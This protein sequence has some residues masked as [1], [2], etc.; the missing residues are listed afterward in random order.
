MSKGGEVTVRHGQTFGVTGSNGVVKEYTSRGVS[1]NKNYKELEGKRLGCFCKPLACHGD[2]IKEL[3]YKLGENMKSVVVEVVK[4]DGTG[5]KA[6]DGWYNLPKGETMAFDLKGQTVEVEATATKP[7]SYAVS[8]LIKGVK[9][10]SGKRTEGGV[11]FNDPKQALIVAQNAL[12]HATNL[13]VNKQIPLKD[14]FTQAKLIADFVFSYVPGSDPKEETKPAP[15]PRQSTKS[16]NAEVP[17]QQS[18]ED[19]DMPF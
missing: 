4:K 1:T 18:P 16:E 3:I 15:R 11:S 10:D 13:V 19:D 12:G 5:F 8:K 17:Y 2:V 14:L 9:N 7:G 6:V